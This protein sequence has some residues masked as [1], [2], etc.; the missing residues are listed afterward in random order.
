VGK[1]GGP[2]RSFGPGS[3]VVGWQEI[4]AEIGPGSRFEFPAAV[5]HVVVRFSFWSKEG[6]SQGTCRLDDVCFGPVKDASAQRVRT[7]RRTAKDAVGLWGDRVPATSGASDPKCLASRLEQAGFGAN[8]LDTRELTDRSVLNAENVDLLILP[9]GGYYPA[10]TRA[11]RG[12]LRSGG[13]LI[14]L[15]GPCFAEPLFPSSD[16]WADSAKT[17]AASPKAI[18]ELT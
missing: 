11:L 17:S 1:A 14:T 13:R 3:S 6:D 12:Y 7:L 9:Y 5:D 10:D 4:R 8:L 2:A 15:G 16:G 18:V